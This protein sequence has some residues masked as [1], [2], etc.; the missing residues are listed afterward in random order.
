[1]YGI[2]RSRSRIGPAAPLEPADGA[3]RHVVV[4]HD[5]AG[6]PNAGETFRGEPFHFGGGVAGGFSV[7]EFDAA[8]GASGVTATRMQDIHAGIVLN[9]EYEALSVWDLDRPVSF[10]RQLWHI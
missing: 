9:R 2:F 5:L 10:N 6:Q 7:Y 8:G 4:A 3:N 1:L